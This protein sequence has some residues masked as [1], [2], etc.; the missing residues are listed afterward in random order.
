MSLES[1]KARE[2]IFSFVQDI[3]QYSIT[4]LPLLFLV[5]GRLFLGI[6]V[7]SII[8][9]TPFFLRLCRCYVV[10]VLEDRKYSTLAPIGGFAFIA[11][12][13]SLLF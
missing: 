5:L 4:R 8:F 10:A 11:A 9:F 7:F 12:W 13:A 1:Q 3:N 6:F 2:T